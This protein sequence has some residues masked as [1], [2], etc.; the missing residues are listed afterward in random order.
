MG[1]I[2]PNLR[3]RE[4]VAI[5]NANKP[6]FDD[7]VLYLE[8]EGYPSLHAF[9]A[10][11][12]DAR[13][14]AAVTKYLGLPSE[15]RLFDG[16]S[17]PYASTRKAKWYF[18]AWLFRDA[19]VQRLQPLLA[20]VPGETMGE[21]QAALINEVRKFVA[22]LLPDPASW[23]W[24]A[25]SEVMLSRLEG[26]RRA[27]KG[28]L[29]ESVVRRSLDE[30]FKAEGLSL[31]VGKRELRLHDETYDVQV[32]GPRTTILIPVKTRETMGGGHANLFTRDIFKSI[33]V[34]AEHGYEA[35]PIVIAESWRGDFASLP[36]EHYIHIPANPNQ[37][38]QIA[39]SLAEELR[40]LLPVFRRLL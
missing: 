26:S 31:T 35:I 7:F 37:T 5:T 14:S 8:G 23:S 20:H 10:D 4:L 24:A 2:L 21:R 15:V 22:P 29:F 3:L 6:F 1:F 17:R 25:V 16:L 38:I 19:P 27:L 18:L 11:E 39:E 13:A 33:S 12:S 28:A 36:C 32:S 9:V 40:K 30:L 34:A